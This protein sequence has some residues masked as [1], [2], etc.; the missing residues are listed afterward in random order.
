MLV[1]ISV[2]VLAAV[3]IFQGVNLLGEQSTPTRVIPPEVRPGNAAAFRWG[4]YLVTFGAV[5]AAVAI[6]SHGCSWLA[7]ILVGL[8]NLGF[9]SVAV[10]GLWLV[11]G[12]KIDYS[13]AP[14]TRDAHSH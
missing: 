9:A 11:F 7:R 13:P 2:Y 14:P 5:L 4:S 10:Y 3:L 1:Y 8:R 12:R 6:M